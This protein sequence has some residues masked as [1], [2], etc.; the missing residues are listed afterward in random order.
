MAE[1]TVA[2]LVGRK[3]S[4]CFLFFFSFFSLFVSVKAEDV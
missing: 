4:S 3:F 2:E 1:E